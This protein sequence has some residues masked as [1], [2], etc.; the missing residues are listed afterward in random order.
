GDG[1]D[2]V[3]LADENWMPLIYRRTGLSIPPIGRAYLFL[4][5]TQAAELDLN[6]AD[7]LWEDFGL[8]DVLA[9]GD[10]N[11]DGYDDFGLGT[12]T[13]M[14][15][16]FDPS[17]DVRFPVMDYSLSVHFGV[18]LAVSGS[19]FFGSMVG[20]DLGDIKIHK[21]DAWELPN[22]QGSYGHLTATSG[23]FNRDGKLDL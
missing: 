22:S 8:S 18:P 3:L 1:L 9:L 20:Y 15:S 5:R 17:I 12:Y 19:P 10:L 23:D 7:L 21:A 16:R 4:G 2:D 13:E 14:G 11:K 6:F